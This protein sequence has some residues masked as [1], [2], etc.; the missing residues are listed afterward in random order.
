[1]AGDDEHG[2]TGQRRSTTPGVVTLITD[3]VGSGLR[4][5]R[6]LPTTA[7]RLPIRGLNLAFTVAEQAQRQAA[8]IQQRREQIVGL[9]NVLRG[10]TAEDDADTLYDR[11]RA[12]AA[13]AATGVADT[14]GD[15]VQETAASVTDLAQ[16]AAER[17]A[18]ERG[19]RTAPDRPTTPRAASA[20]RQPAKRSPARPAPGPTRPSPDAPPQAGPDAASRPR[21]VTSGGQLPTPAPTP[22]EPPVPAAPPA[23]APG[24][25]QEAIDVGA[26]GVAHDVSVAAERAAGEHLVSGAEL[27]SGELPVPDFDHLSIGALRSR[28]PRLDRDQLVQLL[29]YERA[30]ADRLQVVTM[31]ENRVAKLER[32]DD[33]A[34]A[35]GP[36]GAKRAASGG[37][38]PT[39]TE[40]ADTEQTAT[41]RAPTKKAAAKKAA[42]KQATAKKST[43]T[44]SAGKTSAGKKSAARAATSEQRAAGRGRNAQDEAVGAPDAAAAQRAAEELGGSTPHP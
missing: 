33:G 23:P 5:V 39:A 40:Q 32:Q 44:K 11:V 1:M 30:H 6:D 20:P 16:H 38:K 2:E 26:P 31:L 8:A 4:L 24:P 29:G 37:P 43:P 14:A 10:A 15:Y 27:T 41:K 17:L 18:P 19:R 3:V 28:L 42:G 7:A 21:K 22:T 34:A 35:G 25:S 13:D 12:E 36:A 9:I